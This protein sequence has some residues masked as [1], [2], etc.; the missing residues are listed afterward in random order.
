MFSFST[1][2]GS[3]T[4]PPTIPGSNLNP[5]R[6]LKQPV[7]AVSVFPRVNLILPYLTLPYPTHPTLPYSILHGKKKERTST[8]SRSLRLKVPSRDLTSYLP[9]KSR[10][11]TPNA[12]ILHSPSPPPTTTSENM[13]GSERSGNS[14]NSAR[15]VS[16]FGM[17][18]HGIIKILPH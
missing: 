12:Y 11:H 5:Y 17:T 15:S 8:I 13:E 7:F 14:G 10:H 1:N 4:S 3:C 6:T 2:H 16:S 18:S 9:I